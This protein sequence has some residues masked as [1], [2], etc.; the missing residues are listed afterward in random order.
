[1]PERMKIHTMIQTGSIESTLENCA[2]IGISNRLRILS[3]AFEHIFIAGIMHPVDFKQFKHLVRD[4]HIT[5][6]ASFTL[7]D[8]K[9]PAVKIDV[10]PFDVRNLK[11]SQ[12]TVIS[13]RKQCFGIQVTGSNESNDFILRENLS[14]RPLLAECRHI[15]TFRFFDTKKLVVVFKTKYGMLKKRFTVMAGMIDQHREI[16]INVNL[17]KVIRY[18]SEIRYSLG[19]M[20]TVISDS[21]FRILS[22][23]KFLD[24]KRNAVAELRYGK[25]RLV[26]CS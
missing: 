13:E 15:D 9:R 5:V 11:S 18:L 10:T 1:M 20:M 23:S 12:T 3:A 22:D 16:I 17:Q 7:F 14:Q 8:K 26:N 19:Y 4:W 21:T 24:E 2:D 6:L 25:Y